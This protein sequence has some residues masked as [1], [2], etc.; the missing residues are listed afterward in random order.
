ML[1]GQGLIGKLVLL[2]A[3]KLIS[4]QVALALDEK[5]RACRAF[6]ELY[7]CLDRLEELNARFVKTLT[8]GT[9]YGRILIGDLQILLPSVDAVSQRF[10]D[11]GNE[12][13]YA[14]DISFAPLRG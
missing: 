10:L 3:E 12:L 7:H 5:K 6:V 11:I 1:S 8:Y 2:I 14:L 4:K 13:Y 9:E